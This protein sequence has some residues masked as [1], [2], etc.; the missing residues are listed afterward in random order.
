MLNLG[1]KLYALRLEKGLTQRDLT[2]RSGVPQP[3]ISN[4]EKGRRDLTVFTLLKLCSAL[5]VRPADVFSE[6]PPTLKKDSM[7]RERLERLAKAVW[8][9]AVVL[10]QNERRTVQLLQNVIPLSKKRKNQKM[11]YSSW[12]ELRRKYSD[13]EIR[14]LTERVHDEKM[15]RHEKKPD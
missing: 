3:N 9:A 14:I 13:V 8:G 6:I 15:R 2:L 7:T 5:E 12:N 4:I 11:I 1:Q 10:N